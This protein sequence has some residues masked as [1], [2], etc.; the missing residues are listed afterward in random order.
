MVIIHELVEVEFFLEKKSVIKIE[1][2]YKEIGC[3]I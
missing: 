1:T 3:V 2:D